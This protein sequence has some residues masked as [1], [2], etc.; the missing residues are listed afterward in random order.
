MK[1]TR[2]SPFTGITRTLDLNITEA[3]VSAYN[4]GALLQ[5]AFPTLNADEREFYKTGIT[6]EEWDQMFGGSKEE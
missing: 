5:N 4:A 3:Q 1:V 2:T 6:G